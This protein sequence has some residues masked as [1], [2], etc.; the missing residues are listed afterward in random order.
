V[1]YADALYWII[2]PLLAVVL[3]AWWLTVR[4]TRD[5]D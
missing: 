5:L 4:G 2:L 1:T 3:L